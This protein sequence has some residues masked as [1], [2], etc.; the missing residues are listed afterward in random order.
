M[1]CAICRG[2]CCESITL[3]IQMATDDLQRFLELRTKPVLLHGAVQRN[4]DVPC[5]ALTTEGRCG[6]YPR[7]P[8][9]CVAFVPGGPECLATVRARRTPEAYEAIKGPDD[10]PYQPL[11]A[12]G[13]P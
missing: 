5:S 9:V 12:N 6:I 4:F 13:S 11:T 1:D 10:P 2:A 8:H 7:R 3:H